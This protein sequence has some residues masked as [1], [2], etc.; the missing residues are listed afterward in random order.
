MTFDAE[1]ERRLQHFVDVMSAGAATC[2]IIP[3]DI[4]VALAH[5]HEQGDEIARLN[6]II[7]I[8]NE[9]YER[10]KLCPDHRDKLSGRCIVCD[11]EKRG[12][13]EERARIAEL[14]ER[15]GTA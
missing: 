13:D 15:N 9:H 7:K 4:A 5:I 8:E 2:V 1:T 3:D 14:E 10:M 11:G 6:L 12:K